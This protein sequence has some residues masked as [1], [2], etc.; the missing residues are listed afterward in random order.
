MTKKNNMPR[1]FVLYDP[2]PFL[3]FKVIFFWKV[4]SVNRANHTQTGAVKGVYD[5]FRKH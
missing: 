2:T 3:P 5:F 1:R 4:M